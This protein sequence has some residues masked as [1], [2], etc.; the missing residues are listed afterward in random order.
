M[1]SKREGSKSRQRA[2]ALKYLL[3][4]STL[5]TCVRSCGAFRKLWTVYFMF[6]FRVC[7]F[8]FQVWRATEDRG[9]A[10][11]DAEA[12]RKGERNPFARK[13]SL[14]CI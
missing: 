5:F 12:A 7:G 6:E 10:Y 8:V 9:A 11:K 1:S 3:A 4:Y 13:H 2:L 14:T